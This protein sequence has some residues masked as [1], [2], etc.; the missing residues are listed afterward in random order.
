MCSYL[1]QCEHPEQSVYD[2]ILII[3]LSSMELCDCGAREGP[4]RI[5]VR[6]EIIEPVENLC[7]L[8]LRVPIMSCWHSSLVK[9]PLLNHGPGW[10]IMLWASHLTVM[11]ASYDFDHRPR[12][13][14]RDIE[15]GVQMTDFWC[16]LVM[17]VNIQ[18]KIASYH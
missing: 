17:N 1:L 13:D 4:Q 14:M 3:F 5:L 2:S 16:N 15:M 18:K 12:G 9:I 8:V 10:T 11:F 7:H 6:T